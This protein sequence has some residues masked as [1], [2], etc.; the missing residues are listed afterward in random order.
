MDAKTAP[1]GVTIAR[2]FTAMEAVKQLETFSD[3]ITFS[4][5]PAHEYT[6]GVLSINDTGWPEI[7]DF[8][9]SEIAR[10][11]GETQPP[12]MP[13]VE[14]GSAPGS[15]STSAGPAQSGAPAPPIEWSHIKTVS[16]LQIDAVRA[17]TRPLTP[18]YYLTVFWPEIPTN[19]L[20]APYEA[21][22]LLEFELDIRRWLLDGLA[23]ESAWATF[24]AILLTALGGGLQQLARPRKLVPAPAEA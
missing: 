23:T 9:Q 11:K 13:T 12:L 18:A 24:I 17:G 4:D 3:K 15:A 19:V 6:I 22:S 8:L 1:Q 21:V 5:N 7:I 2:E 20:R 10:R 14:P 16:L